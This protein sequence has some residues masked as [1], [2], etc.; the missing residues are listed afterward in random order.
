ML[1]DILR[2]VGPALASAMAQKFEN[3]EFRF[4]D[5]KFKFADFNFEN[6]F[7]G[8]R[9][10]E[11][12]LTEA[13]PDAINLLGS[14]KLTLKEG[15]TFRVKASGEGADTLRFAMHGE[16]LT[17]MRNTRGEQGDERQSRHHAPS[18]GLSLF[19]SLHWKEHLDPHYF[20][21]SIISIAAGPAITTK[22]DGRMKVISGTLIMAGKRA[23]FSSIAS[24]LVL[25]I[26]SART[27]SEC[28][29][30]VP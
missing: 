8:K 7:E 14:T 23:A 30:E 10:E 12:D 2:A 24:I 21:I 3:G 15:K 11:L 19:G 5:S 29:S 13:A 17:I 18:E 16:S 27:R 6:E 1:N 9:L 22:I 4:G 20:M 25:R 26:S 28:A